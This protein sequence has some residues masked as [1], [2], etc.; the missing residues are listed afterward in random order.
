M[1]LSLKDETDFV[2]QAVT[3][4]DSTPNPSLHG[5]GLK[6]HRHESDTPVTASEIETQAAYSVT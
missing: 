6:V 3:N 5:T 2:E 4:L 1:M